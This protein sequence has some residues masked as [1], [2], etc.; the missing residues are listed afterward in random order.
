MYPAHEYIL[1]NFNTSYKIDSY[2]FGDH[3]KKERNTIF[4]G[5]S[6]LFTPII[7]ILKTIVTREFCICIAYYK[8]ISKWFWVSLRIKRGWVDDN[9]GSGW[10]RILNYIWNTHSHTLVLLYAVVAGQH[11]YLVQNIIKM[12]LI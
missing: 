9:G 1:F 4:C 6:H 2:C 7:R 10:Q 5:R 8:K 11:P 3:R 12:K